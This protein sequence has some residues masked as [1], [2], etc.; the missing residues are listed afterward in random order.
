MTLAFGALFLNEL[1]GDFQHLISNNEG[2]VTSARQ[3]QYGKR[4]AAVLLTSVQEG[5]YLGSEW[6]EILKE[7][8]VQ[9]LLWQ[10]EII[11]LPAI[12]D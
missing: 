1:I 6:P 12:L 10:C 5:S 2:Q 4:C 3:A 8:D 7:K 11:E 9:N